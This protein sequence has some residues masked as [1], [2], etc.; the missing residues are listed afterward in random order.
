MI[1]IPR[2][3]MTRAA[4]VIGL[5]QFLGIA[6]AWAQSCAA[7]DPGKAARC[8]GLEEQEKILSAN[9]RVPGAATAEQAASICAQVRA[10]VQ[11]DKRALFTGST[12]TPGAQPV[13]AE[14]EGL[15]PPPLTSAPAKLPVLRGFYI[16]MPMQQA[17]AAASIALAPWS[18]VYRYDKSTDFLTVYL[19]SGP[20]NEPS[21]D[22][23]V[24]DELKQ[25]KEQFARQ[26]PDTT[27][28]TS[29]YP[30]LENALNKC[31]LGRGS[32][33]GFDRGREGGLQFQI[34][35]DRRTQTVERVTITQNY[36]WG[37]HGYN[38]SN[39]NLTLGEFAKLMGQRLGVTFQLGRSENPT[40]EC[41]RSG[42]DVFHSGTIV[43]NTK[44]N[45]V[46][47]YGVVDAK[48][49]KCN[50]QIGGKDWAMYLTPSG[51]PSN[52]DAVR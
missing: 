7:L 19:K 41:G 4:I 31:M 18:A 30:T 38:L 44:K 43:C 9:C 11:A 16:G 42:G 14:S 6:S 27:R 34:N 5:S 3:R 39:A 36:L 2:R 13:F 49:C 8:R 50:L 47:W 23:C 29:E 45:E 40:A 26:K 21:L 20:E 46:R 35:I 17:L 12:L 33:G 51:K 32:G 25:L 28:F 10:K 24:A 48:T 37:S 15:R 52:P 22:K 1:H